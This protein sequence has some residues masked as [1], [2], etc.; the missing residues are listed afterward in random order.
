MYLLVLVS[1]LELLG[2]AMV[3]LTGFP[4]GGRGS[5]YTSCPYCLSNDILGSDVTHRVS[6]GGTSFQ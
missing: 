4:W 2:I 5:L 1:V 6:L 3:D